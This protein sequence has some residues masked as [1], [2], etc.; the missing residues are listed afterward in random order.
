MDIDCQDRVGTGSGSRRYANY[1]YHPRFEFKPST[2][3]EVPA[4]DDH[5]TK[6][7]DITQMLTTELE[8][9]QGIYQFYA[10]Q[11]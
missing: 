9:A 3:A 10:D 11:H 2:H 6:M 5:V 7:Q 8:L 1:G 4:A